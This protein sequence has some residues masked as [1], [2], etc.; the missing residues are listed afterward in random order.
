MNVFPA[1]LLFWGLL[2][3][4]RATC[5]T[6]YGD[7]IRYCKAFQTDYIEGIEILIFE[8]RD[9]G[10]INS[11]VFS[12]PNLKS[13][14]SLTLK[15][16]KIHTIES[17]AFQQFRSLGNMELQDNSLTALSP[18]WFHDP[19]TLRNLTLA[20]NLIGRLRPEMLQ[21]F[22]NLERL[23]L[24]RNQITSI[25]S[26]S[27]LGVSKMLSLDLSYNKISSVQWQTLSPL[28][29][30]LRLGG[31]PWNCSCA[32]RDFILFLKEM[33]NASRL[34]DPTSVTCRYPPDLTGAFVWNVT[35]MN[36]SSPGLLPRP[37]AVFH[38]VVLPVLFVVLG[39]LFFSMSVWLIFCILTSR[40][41]NKVTNMTDP[42]RPIHRRSENTELHHDLKGR[43]VTHVQDETL[44]GSLNR[45]PQTIEGSE[46]PKV[47]TVLPPPPPPHQNDGFLHSDLRSSKSEPMGFSIDVNTSVKVQPATELYEQH[48]IH[49]AA[50]DGTVTMQNIEA[51]GKSDSHGWQWTCTGTSVYGNRDDGRSRETGLLTY[52]ETHIDPMNDSKNVSNT[53][54]SRV[55]ESAPSIQRDVS[56]SNGSPL[57]FGKKCKTW[58][59]FCVPQ[60]KFTVDPLESLHVPDALNIKVDFKME[61][62]EGICKREGLEETSST[63]QEDSQREASKSLNTLHADVRPCIIGEGQQHKEVASDQSQLEPKEHV[64]DS[65][66][67]GGPCRHQHQELSRKNKTGK[68]KERSSVSH[69]KLAREKLWKYH[70]NC[71]SEFEPCQ[72]ASNVLRRLKTPEKGEQ[73]TTEVTQEPPS[74]EDLLQ[75]TPSLPLLLSEPPESQILANPAISSKKICSSLPNLGVYGV[76]NPCVNSANS[77]LRE[78]VDV[79]DKTRKENISEDLSMCSTDLPVIDLP[80]GDMESQERPSEA[81]PSKTNLPKVDV[82]SKGLIKARGGLN[83]ESSAHG[84]IGQEISPTNSARRR[85]S[86]EQ[87]SGPYKPDLQVSNGQVQDLISHNSYSPVLPDISAGGFCDGTIKE[88][89]M[90][91]VLPPSDLELPAINLQTEGPLRNEIHHKMSPGDLHLPIIDDSSGDNTIRQNPLE[92]ELPVNLDDSVSEVQ[93]QSVEKFTDVSP[94]LPDVHTLHEDWLPNKVDLFTT[95]INESDPNAT[96]QGDQS[97]PAM[98]EPPED[99]MLA[100]CKTFKLGKNRTNRKVKSKSCPVLS[101]MLD[102]EDQYRNPNF[103][104]EMLKSLCGHPD[105]K[106]KPDV[107]HTRNN[108]MVQPHSTTCENSQEVLSVPMKTMN[109]GSQESPLSNKEQELS[110]GGFSDMNTSIETQLAPSGSYSISTQDGD[111]ISEWPNTVDMLKQS[112]TISLSSKYDILDSSA[113]PQCEDIGNSTIPYDGHNVNFS[114]CGMDSISDTNALQQNDHTDEDVKYKNTLSPREKY[115]SEKILQNGRILEEISVRNSLLLSEEQMTNTQ[116]PPQSDILD[117]AEINDQ[118]MDPTDLIPTL[119]EGESVKL[120]KTRNNQNVKTKSCPVISTMLNVQDQDRNPNNNRELPKSTCGQPD[121]K[122]CLPSEE[123]KTDAQR[124]PQSDILD[125]AE[126]TDQTLDHVDLIQMSDCDEIL[127]GRKEVQD[128]S[129]DVHCHQFSLV[130]NEQKEDPDGHHPP[131]EATKV[132]SGQLSVPESKGKTI[133]NEENIES[134]ERIINNIR[135]NNSLTE[136]YNGNLDMSHVNHIATDQSDDQNNG[137]STDMFTCS[138]QKVQ[139]NYQEDGSAR[140]EDGIKQEHNSYDV[141]DQKKTSTLCSN[142]SRSKVVTKKFRKN[143]GAQ[144]LEA[145]KTFKTG[146]IIAPRIQDIG[147]DFKDFVSIRLFPRPFQSVFPVSA[148]TG[149]IEERPSVNGAEIISPPHML[150]DTLSQTKV[151]SNDPE[152][153][154]MAG[155]IE[156]LTYLYARGQRLNISQDSLGF[157]GRD[158]KAVDDIRVLANLQFCKVSGGLIADAEIPKTIQEAA[159]DTNSTFSVPDNPYVPPSK[160]ELKADDELAVLNIMCTLKKSL[161]LSPNYDTDGTDT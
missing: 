80:A 32:H 126:M 17:G 147:Q 121:T 42:E 88:D 95:L 125:R 2:P 44:V 159:E 26:E 4:S 73:K 16:S 57:T 84:S 110:A 158:D 111:E 65:R 74:D 70:K 131:N 140:D 116:R 129:A 96:L 33:M 13:V 91:Q 104:R 113:V 30:T 47:Q 81:S 106:N 117:R 139:N 97:L 145:N 37:E 137:K 92:Q 68:P 55:E 85:T 5:T 124:P 25:H 118:T 28:N 141:E 155:A 75:E 107:R 27:F 132:Q 102:I 56:G 66:A 94:G 151:T 61:P 136:S 29:G 46:R 48:P 99:K 64:S 58:S 34:S 161:E 52:I 103:K 38:R 36:C 152:E 127:T 157:P 83:D 72:T 98:A 21:G 82:L 93:V 12:S 6:A 40:C 133:E 77:P 149:C 67:V 24:S 156:Y 90:S 78:P 109:N 142:L 69:E 114:I 153:K 41:K 119:R 160:E 35:E 87:G 112:S 14:L 63:H 101:E 8:E 79:Q 45:Y 54:E 43:L 76:N 20:N 154:T 15:G 89:E 144:K 1:L 134:K 23:N 3:G 146:N 148:K 51:V 123:Q 62:I 18:S 108:D 9:V 150:S 100:E 31:N 143:I 50:P 71:C 11:T 39:A 128:P 59:T 115:T 122:T 105:T 120:G 49:P 22:S 135:H 130:F 10:R 86:V 19:A 138:Q 7:K 60:D 53:G